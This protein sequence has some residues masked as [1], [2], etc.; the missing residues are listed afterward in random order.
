[1]KKSIEIPNPQQSFER[2]HLLQESKVFCMAPW[3]QMDINWNAAK[4]CCWSNNVNWNLKQREINKFWN[5]PELRRLRNDMLAGKKNPICRGCYAT[6]ANA[7]RS[8]RQQ[9]NEEYAGYFCRVEAS[10]DGKAK[11]PPAV[12]NIA[13]SN[14]CNFRC[15]MCGPWAS[16][17]WNEDAQKIFGTAWVNAALT[18]EW[19]RVLEPFLPYLD[20]LHFAGGEPLLEPQHYELLRFLIDRGGPRPSITY[21]TNFSVM[22]RGGDDVMTLW[23]EF[24]SVG[25]AASL[26][27]MGKRGEYI[28]KGQRWDQVIQNRERM[29]KVCPRV[30]FMISPTI[31]LMN[32]LH[33]PD[34]HREWLV[35]GYIDIETG[36]GTSAILLSRPQFYSVQVLPPAL[37]RQVEGKYREHAYWISSSYGARAK[38]VLRYYQ[39]IIDSMMARDESSRLYEFRRWTALLDI[40]RR[41]MFEQTFPELASLMEGGLE[42]PPQTS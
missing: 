12:L 13:L 19:R 24:K 26:D 4:P 33:L 41:E 36:L 34:F 7:C 30:H 29:L 14:L 18:L 25:V 8:L 21:N 31:S 28:R 40:V 42:A 6:E 16:S 22:S 17:A 32:A 15:R 3:V 23:N 2:D 37:K 39:T 35:R 5:G 20:R 38:A 10:V 1:M 9:M 11:H 27:G